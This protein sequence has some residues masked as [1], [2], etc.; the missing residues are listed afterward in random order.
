MLQ[1]IQTLYLLLAT[2]CILLSFIF[3]FAK[4]DVVS[5]AYVF[6]TGGMLVNDKN[7]IALPYDALIGSL[8][9]YT[10]ITILLY[11]KRPLQILMGRLNYLFH[12]VLL[13]LIY[14][15]AKGAIEGLENPGAAVVS[16]GAGFY[17]IA[18]SFAFVFLA[19]RAIKSDENLV[20]SLDRLR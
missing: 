19:T 3:S 11:K 5:V 13:V 14:L 9:L 6:D 20:R 1:R 18:A 16:F 4:I 8:A 15:N 10:F 2:V 12:I 17:L 7:L